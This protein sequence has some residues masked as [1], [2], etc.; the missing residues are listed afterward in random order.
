[1]RRQNYLF[2]SNYEILQSLICFLLSHRGCEKL[3]Q[4]QRQWKNEK[5]ASSD[6][7]VAL[8]SIIK[9]FL[10]SPVYQHVTFVLL[11]KMIA[12]VPKFYS[13]DIEDKNDYST[14]IADIIT[15]YIHDNIEQKPDL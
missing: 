8:L 15:Q 7:F 2:F 11:F 10:K 3:L 9:T 1:M 4:L 6:R 5:K 14:L 13:A 12:S